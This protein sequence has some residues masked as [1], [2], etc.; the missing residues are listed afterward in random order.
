MW[1]YLLVVFVEGPFEHLVGDV[2]GHVKRP[3]LG[4]VEGDHG[5][6]VLISPSEEISDDRAA[7]GLASFSRK[8]DRGGQSR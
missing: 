8:P 7:V 5:E 6:R 2:L 3:A 1:S 4:S